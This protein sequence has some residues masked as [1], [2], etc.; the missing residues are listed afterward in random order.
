[1][2][3]LFALVVLAC[4]VAGV[5][6]SAA[7]AGSISD[8]DPCPRGSNGN[9]ICPVGTEGIAYSIKFHGDEDP[10]CA[11]GDDKWYAANGS[12]PPGLT[13]ADNGQLS[14]TPTQAG[15]Y[16][17]WLE[18]KLPDYF[19]PEENR[20]CSSRDNS[21][22]PVTITIN[23]GIPRLVIG[24]ESAPPG[25]VS[26]QYSLQMTATV[27]D[28]KTWT[29][30][31]G[32]LPA[33]LTLDPATGLI[34]GTPTSAGTYTF[35]VLARVN[36]DA[37]TDT[38][39]LGI[40]VRDALAISATDPFSPTRRA[41]AEVTAPFSAILA[42]TGGDGVYTWSLA[43]GAL[44]PGLTLNAG[45]IE[46][47]PTV[48]GDYRF[49]VRVADAE[50]RVANYA[51]RVTVAA[52]LAFLTPRLLLPGTV[53]KSYRAKLATTGGVK[54][55]AWRLVR[56][57]LPRGVRFDRFLGILYGFPT[58]PGRSTFTIEARDELGVVT[59]RVFRL[60]VKPA[61]KPKLKRP[62]T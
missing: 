4:A 22:E 2:K 46:G 1:L 41:P 36:A 19:I 31:S 55:V 17:F 7:P 49:V 53:G 29:I 8:I 33:G 56:G 45:L 18:L 57:P 27:S 35:E 62:R 42:A 6:V 10:I 14:G 50:G 16:S 58:R 54:P 12:V 3:R 43:S 34:S 30:N 24:P 61:L 39:T 44:P 28:P 51:A 15:T 26:A 23:P 47:T 38:K 40:V 20:G 21:E 59:T 9:L 5:L 37:R 11:P 48:A 60:V 13:L 32:A 25:T 52:K